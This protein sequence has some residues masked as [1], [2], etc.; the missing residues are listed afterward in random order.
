MTLDVENV[1]KANTTS[2][3]L[4]LA[5]GGYGLYVPAY[6]RPY[7]WGKKE[8]QRLFEDACHGVAQVLT[9]PDSL[10]FIGSII[11]I[12]DTKHETINPIVKGHVPAGVL[13]VIDGQ[14]RL[15][16]LLLVNAL[17]H[18]EIRHR[19]SL[20][21]KKYGGELVDWLSERVAQ[22]GA[23]LRATFEH[24]TNVGEPTDIFRFYPKMIRAFVDRWSW[25]QSKAAYE[26]PVAQLLH[27]Y[28]RHY[29]SNPGNSKFVFKKEDQRFR[30]ISNAVKE[31]QRHLKEII[32]GPQHTSDEDEDAED[33][34]E[35]PTRERL[36]ASFE[37]LQQFMNAEFS[38]VIRERLASSEEGESTAFQELFRL[39]LFAQY[40]LDRVAL[41][42][43]IATSE[44]Y[45]FDVFES[46]NTT[47]TPLTAVET[48]KPRVISGEGLAHWERSPLYGLFKKV[49]E[50]LEPYEKPDDKQSATNRLLVAFAL[51]EN[52]HK[53]SRHLSEQRRYLRDRYQD[54]SSSDER[55]QEFIAG[56]A[57]VASYIQCAWDPKRN[58][59]DDL[60]KIAGSAE[61]GYHQRHVAAICL[62]VLRQSNH[63]I[64]I[65]P[66]AA[67]Y[68]GIG[69]ANTNQERLD[70]TRSFEEALVAIV[71]FFALW[72]SSREGTKQIDSR[73]RQLMSG[74]LSRNARKGS[75]QDVSMLK[76]KLRSFLEEAPG[77]GIRS[78]TDWLRFLRQTPHY[79]NLS[80]AL[81][82]FLLFLA[83]NDTVPD[84]NAP[85][86]VKVGT[87]GVL[88]L[89]SWERWKQQT[90]IEH[91]TP[92]SRGSAGYS[93]AIY[94]EL[95]HVHGLGNLTLL[96]SLV[97]S[98][99]G[100]KSWE[101]KRTIYAALSG[102]T[103]SE[104]SSSLASHTDEK[105]NRLSDRAKEIVK[106]AGFLPHVAAL[107]KLDVPEITV[108]FIER[109]TERIGLIAWSWLA[110]ALGYPE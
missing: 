19:H 74:S 76:A 101:A 100:K 107:A 5:Q 45:A 21:Q 9:Y 28:I 97:N 40:M 8:V 47:G 14:Q 93:G 70:A 48:F 77:V 73:Y 60:G 26:S 7:S 65:A 58:A 66:L 55:K 35:L 68:S 44:D 38:P 16:T 94:D 49:D 31:I 57:D 71:S 89:L 108:D 54:C 10:T 15:T 62:D 92:Q 25:Q 91:I 88:P 98:S 61:G 17:L 82:R 53:L 75:P 41:T 23:R 81:V 6:Q 1:F 36:V 52:G 64:T 99:L 50:F 18:H 32:E 11:L 3:H 104:V 87:R 86:L 59:Y 39:L 72:R 24:D 27:D 43:V 106:E 29:H 30:V 63:D 110:A 46:L 22:V 2:A 69:K 90:T 85:G 96:P 105:G 13:L 12:R 109:R 84:E 95:R 51:Y 33:R 4:L 56:L 34:L 78:R 80:D 37:Y 103:E 20:F 79:K 42:S 67:F 83:A 102:K